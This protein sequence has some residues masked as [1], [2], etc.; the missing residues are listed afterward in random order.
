L[1]GKGKISTI[2]RA[3]IVVTL[4]VR[5]ILSAITGRSV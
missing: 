3:R 4:T 1:R 2:K 5:Q